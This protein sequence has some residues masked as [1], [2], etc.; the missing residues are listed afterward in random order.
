MV[1]L[2]MPSRFKFF[3][4]CLPQ[5]LLDPLLNTLPHLLLLFRIHV[6]LLLLLLLSLLLL[7]LL[8]FTILYCPPLSK[9]KKDRTTYYVGIV[10]LT[11]EI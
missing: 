7:L 6:L 2:K 8:L 11:M 1:Y 5:I 3:K 10:C 9:K 4:G